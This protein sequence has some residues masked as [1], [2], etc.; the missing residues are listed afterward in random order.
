MSGADLEYQRMLAQ[1]GLEADE[2][3]GLDGA[4]LEQL[5]DIRAVTDPPSSGGGGDLETETID[6]GEDYRI[7]VF[8]N[9]DVVAIPVDTP[10]PLP[11]TGLA[12]EVTLSA[13]RLSWLAPASG[14][15]AS[16]QIYRDN[17]LIGTSSA[18]TYRD[19]GIT[20]SSTYVYKV[21]TVDPYGQVSVFTSTV[22]AFI[23]PALNVAPVVTV[24]SWPAAFN[25]AGKTILRVCG[26]DA[27]AQTLT[28]ALEVDDGTITPTDDPSVWYYTP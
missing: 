3:V 28:Y 4:R 20:V 6:T 18:L 13:V 5:G 9:G 25:A 14:T 22:T 27:N 12:R 11:P 15:V 17:V 8:S 1:A 10:D 19:T 21:R 26:T 24:T 16:Y 2:A 7:I 23:D